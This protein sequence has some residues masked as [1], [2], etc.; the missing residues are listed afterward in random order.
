MALSLSKVKAY[1]PSTKEQGY[2]TSVKSNGKVD[3]DTIVESACKNTTMHKV[4]LRMAHPIN[5][6]GSGI[7]N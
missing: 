2:R 7:Q 3:M 5:Q 4:E 6:W 1:N